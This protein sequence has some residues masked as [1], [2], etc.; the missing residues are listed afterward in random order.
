MRKKPEENIKAMRE[1]G[2]ER[3]ERDSYK[4][5][6]SVMGRDKKRTKGERDG[7]KVE[8]II[9]V[10]DIDLGTLGPT[11]SMV[12]CTLGIRCTSSWKSG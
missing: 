12:S 7:E 5:W 4:C 8:G 9:Q 10:L 3:R 11:Q 6:K 1:R 2:N